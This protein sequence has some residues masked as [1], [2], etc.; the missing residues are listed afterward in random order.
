ML[1]RD[2]YSRA[3]QNYMSK[4]IK[5]LIDALEKV[6]AEKMLKRGLNSYLVDVDSISCDLYDYEKDDATPDG[7]NRF[8]G[9][10]MKQYSWAE[11]TLARLHWKKGN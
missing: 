5:E 11:V 4:I 6:G 1:E 7:P 2:D 8:Y 3:T 10:C 9:E